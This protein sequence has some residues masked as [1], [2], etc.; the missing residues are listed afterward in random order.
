VG[1]AWAC[2]KPSDC[3]AAAPT[4][5]SACTVNGMLCPYGQGEC[6]CEGTQ[7]DC[8]GI[9]RPRTDG[10]VRDAGTSSVVDAA[11]IDAARP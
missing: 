5:R 3:P 10:G 11:T 7:W 4:E 2:W 6:E 1:R 9:P 8:S